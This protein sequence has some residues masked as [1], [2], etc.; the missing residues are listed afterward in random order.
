MPKWTEPA[1]DLLPLIGDW[2]TAAGPLYSR[3]ARAMQSA[4]EGGE[5]VAGTRLP[6]ERPLAEA[7][8]VSR[9]TVVLAY[10]KLR[11]QGLLESRQGSGTWVPR[12]TASSRPAPRDERS[13]SFL[14]DSLARAAS[15]APADTI[16]FMGACLPGSGLALD[17]EWRAAEV[18][19]AQLACGTGYSPQGW[20]RRAI[21]AHFEARGVPTTPDETCD[22]RRAAAIDRLGRFCSAGARPSC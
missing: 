9:T 3:L 8:G 16:T 10:G 22:E 1:L 18:D 12:P 2:S 21:A 19:V 14:V 17:E 7:L 6:P 4:I 13:R 20:P 11:E 5:L 15:D